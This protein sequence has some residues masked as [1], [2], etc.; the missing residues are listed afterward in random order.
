MD[1]PCIIELHMFCICYIETSFAGNQF[2][3]W[4]ALFLAEVLVQC[5][6]LLM[7][8]DEVGAVVFDIGTYTTK[9]GYAG[10]DTPKVCVLEEKKW[11]AVLLQ[12]TVQSLCLNTQGAFPSAVGVR[13]AD[14]ENM[15]DTADETDGPGIYFTL[16]IAWHQCS[17]K[18]GSADKL[19]HRDDKHL[20]ATPRHEFFKAIEGWIEYVCALK[21]ID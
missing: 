3:S 8:L 15:M 5:F 14:V 17:E 20:H 10:E 4:V 21:A 1:H 6:G 11:F 12:V 7:R 16:A 18:E 19:F 2:P 13:S 9:A